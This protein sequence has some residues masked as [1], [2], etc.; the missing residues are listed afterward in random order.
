MALQNLTGKKYGW[1]TVMEIDPVFSAGERRW[2][3]K[4]ECGTQRSVLERS[5]I[6]GGSTNCGCRRHEGKP[7]QQLIGQTFGQLKVIAYQQQGHWLCQCSCQKECSCTTTQLLQGK[8]T[9]CGCQTVRKGRIADLTGRRFHRLVA[10]EPLPER[11]S[12]GSVV[13]RCR[14]DCGKEVK[15]SRHMLLDGN[16]KSCGCQKHEHDKILFTYLNHVDGT[17]I[18]MIKSST[19]PKN[20][21]TGVKGVYLV[22]G[23]YVAK[24]VVKGCQYYLGTYETLEK[25]SEIRRQAEKSLQE[26]LIPYWEK[27]RSRA[28]QDPEWREANPVMIEVEKTPDN[29]VIL[30]IAPQLC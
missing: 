8:R 17:S 3:C 21:T 5:L 30:H 4:C 19:V 16:M 20:N 23:K 9:H 18:E 10:L 14:C 11:D 15:A 24:I 22:K 29:Q 13:W 7:R 1:W 2:I 25:A 12:K 27:W 26:Q 28:E 6:Y